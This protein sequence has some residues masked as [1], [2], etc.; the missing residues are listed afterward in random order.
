MKLPSLSE[1]DARGIV[2]PLCGALPGKPCTRGTGARMKQ[3]HFH[4]YDAAERA[5]RAAQARA[6]SRAQTPLRL[7][8]P[9]RQRTRGES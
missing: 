6:E 7:R 8:V 4:R 5:L 9:P 2:C 1:S 3:S